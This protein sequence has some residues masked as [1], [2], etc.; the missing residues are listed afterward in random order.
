MIQI[1]QGTAG[2]L[3]VFTLN[4]Q[5]TI[6]APVH[7]LFQFEGLNSGYSKVFM[8]VE[9]SWNLCR[10][11]MINIELVDEI[12]EDLYDSKINL[13]GGR[14]NY[15]VY[16]QNSPTNLD[17]N[18]TEGVV[19][20]GFVSVNIPEVINSYDNNDKNNIIYG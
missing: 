4:E 5:T 1:N 6:V 7:Y 17:I 13:A 12:D 10:F 3:S 2:N 15:T 16:Q 8:G 18:L 14:Y 20:Q 11:N 19:E 9:L